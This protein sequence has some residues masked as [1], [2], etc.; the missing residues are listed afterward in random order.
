MRRVVRIGTLGVL[1]VSVELHHATVVLLKILNALSPVK[2]DGH[3]D[4]AVSK[5]LG[6]GL[7]VAP[8]L[9]PHPGERVAEEVRVD[10]AMTWIRMLHAGAV[11]SATDKIVDCPQRDR[12]A[13][14]RDEE[15]ASLSLSEVHLEVARE[16]VVEGD[17]ARLGLEL[18]RSD[19]HHATMVAKEV[20][21]A[22]T[23]LPT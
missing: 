1:A 6:E 13:L 4:R 18:T 5:D 11:T 17:E 10:R 16:L 21:D 3:R 19:G 9:L 23:I 20:R 7:E 14:V 8:V 15:R 22:E 12:V 2:V